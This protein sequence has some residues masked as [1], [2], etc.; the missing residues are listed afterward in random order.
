MIFKTVLHNPYKHRSMSGSRSWSASWSMSGSE[1]WSRSG[2]WSWPW[3]NSW[4]L[5]GG[6]K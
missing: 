5:F 4:L 1:N 3:Y 6:Q 2:S